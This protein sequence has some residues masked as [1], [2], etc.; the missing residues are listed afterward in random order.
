MAEKPY[1]AEDSRSPIKEIYHNMEEKKQGICSIIENLNNHA[2]S[3]GFRLDTH[4][5]FSIT[6]PEFSG[7]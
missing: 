3:G 6:C 2:E 1:G 4:C 7:V 5:L